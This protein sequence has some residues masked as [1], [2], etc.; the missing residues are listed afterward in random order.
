MRKPHVKTASLMKRICLLTLWL[1][2]LACEQTPLQIEAIEHKEDYFFAVELR[3]TMHT[4]FQPLAYRVGDTL[5]VRYPEWTD[6]HTIVTSSTVVDLLPPAWDSTFLLLRAGFNSWQWNINSVQFFAA[7]DFRMPGLVRGQMPTARMLEDYFYPG[8]SL[9]FGHQIDQVDVL[10]GLP[11][12]NGQIALPSRATFLH[13]PAGNLI[14]TGI[15]DYEHP[16]FVSSIHYPKRGKRITC[17]FEGEIGRFDQEKAA[18]FPGFI[19][20]FR[21]AVSIP[22]L[23]GEAAFFV[24]YE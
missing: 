1:G 24:A 16:Y 8:R 2:L 7:F 22:L 12:G 20:D 4:A 13:Q 17:I 10:I 3:D 18:G 21:T 9:A 23:R 14:I 6:I 11:E 19:H 5:S 15:E